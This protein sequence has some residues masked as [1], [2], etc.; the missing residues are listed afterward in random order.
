AVVAVLDDLLRVVPGAAGVGQQD[1]HQ[2][3][4][5]DRPGEVAG[6]GRGPEPEADGDG[7]GDREQAGG[8]QLAQRVAGDD[9]D[10]AAVLRLRGAVHDPGDLPELAA[11]LVD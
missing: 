8:G 10:H 4:G 11:H 2:H 6:Q 1:R 5:R 3:A 7:G 9:V